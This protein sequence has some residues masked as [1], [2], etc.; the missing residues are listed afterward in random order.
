[1]SKSETKQL[2]RLIKKLNEAADMADSLELL[3]PNGA[4]AGS[5][6][7]GIADDLESLLSES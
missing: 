6:I 4:F 1:M 3:L 7:G 2:K 5:L